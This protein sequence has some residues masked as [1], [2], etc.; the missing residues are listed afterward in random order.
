MKGQSE[1]DEAGFW[2]TI[3][4]EMWFGTNI[5]YNFQKALE[6]N[7]LKLELCEQ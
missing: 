6:L 1:Y 3:Y 7:Q 2:P 5:H 4:H